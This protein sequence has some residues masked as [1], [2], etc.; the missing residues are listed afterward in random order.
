[1]GLGCLMIDLLFLSNGM[2]ISDWR[3]RDALFVPVWVQLPSIHLKLWSKGI[4]RRIASLVRV[5]LYMDKAT[6]TGEQIS[7]A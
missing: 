4:I 7:Y 1:M 5:P 6:S 3:E 2:N